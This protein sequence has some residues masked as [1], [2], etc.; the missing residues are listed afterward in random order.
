MKI[1]ISG[2]FLCFRKPNMTF[3][4]HAW[5]HK[6]SSKDLICIDTVIR[7]TSKENFDVENLVWF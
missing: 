4:L 5:K 7:S 3:W 6:L 1:Q 2:D